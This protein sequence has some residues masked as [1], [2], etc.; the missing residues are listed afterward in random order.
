MLLQIN[1]SGGCTP[2]HG[3]FTADEITSGLGKLEITQE[4]GVG[5]TEVTAETEGRCSESK[6]QHCDCRNHDVETED[7]CESAEKVAERPSHSDSIV[8]VDLCEET[9]DVDDDDKDEDNATETEEQGMSA[10]SDCMSA[11]TLE[12]STPAS[13][14]TDDQEQHVDNE[15]VETMSK[16]FSDMS[17]NEHCHDENKTET[18]GVS[19]I[20]RSVTGD[21]QKH[22]CNAE[23]M[24]LTLDCSSISSEQQN[25]SAGGTMTLMSD[26]SS[27]GNEQQHDGNAETMA[28][29]SDCNRVSNEQQRDGNAETMSLMSD[30]SHV[31][32]EQQCDC[33]LYTSPSP[34][35]S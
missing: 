13:H 4:V 26:C 15:T 3:E 33:L 27:V 19:S 29:M 18:D 20:S 21:E 28:L 30:C 8:N 17:F 22:D 12:T 9:S 31:S 6:D 23:A 5:T 2:T 34:R 24:V 7:C 25:D 10:V 11:L 1:R 32:N 16:C 14:V 35:D